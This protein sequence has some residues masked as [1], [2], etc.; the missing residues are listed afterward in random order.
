MNVDSSDTG[1][2]FCWMVGNTNLRVKY[3]VMTQHVLFFQSALWVSRNNHMQRNSQA[4]NLKEPELAAALSS[5]LSAAD[6]KCAKTFSVLSVASGTE[7]SNMMPFWS[8]V[9]AG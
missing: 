4:R 9:I 5:S 8:L 6:A 3:R 2:T 7:S 1:L